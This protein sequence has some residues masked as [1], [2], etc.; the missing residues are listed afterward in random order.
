MNKWNRITANVTEAENAVIENYM[1]KQNLAHKNQAI[2][3]A[4]QESVGFYP[5]WLIVPE[6]VKGTFW[7]HDH[8]IEPVIDPITRE[9]FKKISLEL[10][11]QL[12]REYRE[13]NFSNIDEESEN[14]IAFLK[15]SKKGR[16]KIVCHRGRPVDT[17]L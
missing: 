3:K 13:E 16:P 5:K 17:G 14:Y 12:W 9:K 11:A 6:S 15:H 10:I 7:L 8:L 2:R 4:L 1:K